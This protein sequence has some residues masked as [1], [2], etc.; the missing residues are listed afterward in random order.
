MISQVI[1]LCSGLIF[2]FGL[3]ISG[4]INPA[5]VKGFLN[6]LS[7]WDYSLIFVLLGAVGFNFFT[8]KY[9]SKKGALYSQKLYLPQGNS[10]DKKLIIGAIIFG[11]GWGIGGICPG[12]A[13]VNLVTLDQNII[14]FI[15]F[16]I[17]GMTF[18]QFFTRS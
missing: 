9:I 14:A 18:A 12:P 15:V 8:F 3:C 1:A 16:M 10:V 7:S 17:F 6:I 4:M 2:A 13:L 5:K 11:I